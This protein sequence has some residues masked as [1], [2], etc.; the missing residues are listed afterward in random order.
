MPQNHTK[1]PEV[2]TE[3]PPPDNT[4]TIAL[5]EQWALADATDDS[6]VIAQANQD[7]AE[8]MAS[9]N[10]NRAADRPIFP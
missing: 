1:E 2:L 6:V 7:L 4:A 5:L 3:L 9:L 8:F 10:A